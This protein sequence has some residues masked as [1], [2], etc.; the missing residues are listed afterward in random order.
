MLNRLFLLFVLLAISSTVYA[1]ALANQPVVNIYKYACVDAPLISQAIYGTTLKILTAKFTKLC[2]IKHRHFGWYCIQTPD[3]YI[4]WVR[5]N[6]VI[7]NSS[8]YSLLSAFPNNFL[9]TVGIKNYV[10]LDASSSNHLPILTLPFNVKLK[11]INQRGERWIKIQLINGKF[12]WIQ[13]GN[14]KVGILKL[15]MLQMLKLSKQFISLPYT[16]GVK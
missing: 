10:Y 12:G 3:Q 11:I 8:Y 1:M 13:Y 9:T 7:K 5:T 4:G 15:I 6:N 14:I 2:N 16:W